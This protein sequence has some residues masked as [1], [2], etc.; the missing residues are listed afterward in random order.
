MSLSLVNTIAFVVHIL[1]IVGILALLLRE[2]NKK[3]RKF[4]PGI[5]H[6]A[7][8]AL[9]A[10]VVM[11]GLRHSLNAENPTDWPLFNNTKIAVKLLIVILPKD[12]LNHYVLLVYSVI[13]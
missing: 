12:Q 3:P 13:H 6:S 4:N 7:L 11:V 1:A 2:W 10:G 9:I 5:L 8:L